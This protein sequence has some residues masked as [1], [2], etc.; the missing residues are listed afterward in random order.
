MREKSMRVFADEERSANL[1]KAREARAEKQAAGELLFHD[2]GSDLNEWRRLASKYG[3]RL[4]SSYIPN[5]EVKYLKRAI[6]KVGADYKHY[7][8]DCGYSNFK[9]FHKDNPDY[10]IY[11]EVG[12]FLEWW[13]GIQS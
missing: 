9:D 4:P 11:A 3:V 7:I 6:K 12:F 10:P 13:D 2:W 5:S 8:E 1:L